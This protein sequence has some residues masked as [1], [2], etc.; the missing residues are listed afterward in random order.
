MMKKLKIVI[1]A[2]LLFGITA[3]TIW[4]F[5]SQD[6][7]VL[8][9]KGIIALKQRSLMITS[10]LLM[11]IVVVPVFIMTAVFAW[12]Y[13]DSNKKAA[14]KPNWDSSHLAE[15]FWWGIPCVI[16]LFLALITWSSSHELS[17]YKPIVTD[18]KPM[19]IQ[20]VALQWKWLFIYPEQNIASLNF[21][22]FP[23]NVPINFEITADAPMNSFWI[24]QLGG[25]IYAMP[26]M[27]T[28]LHLMASEV[29]EF[30]GSSANISGD[31]FAGMVF[32]AKASSEK[33]FE[34]WVGSVRS[35][36]QGLTLDVYNN[37]VNPSQYNPP[38]FYLLKKEGLFD[39]IIMKY[40]M[41]ME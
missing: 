36:G 28:Q 7:A 39:E 37:L 12:K 35:S 4:F 38:A 10:T 40:L 16:V 1:I 13:R 21:V 19:T 18:K 22:Q 34:S 24:P 26:A 32:T 30:R 17:P 15:C 8:N 11:L 20:V 14:Y 25:Q 41:P 6:I 9:P 27:K 31:G 29:G 3:V 23:E 2:C 5:Y 33:D